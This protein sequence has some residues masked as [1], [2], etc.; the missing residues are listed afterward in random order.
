LEG[1]FVS[2]SRL[3]ATAARILHRNNA[4]DIL[5][6]L[7]NLEE[8]RAQFT[9]RWVW[10]LIQNARD[11]PDRSRPMTIRIVVSPQEIIFAHNGRDFADE[12]ILSLIYHGSTKQSNP[13][14]L[15]QFGTGFLSTHLLSKRVQVRGTL[16]DREG[17]RTGFEFNL[18]RSGDDADKVGAATRRSLDELERSLET[19]ERRPSVWTEYTY[20]IDGTLNAADLIAD[21]PFEAI[22]YILVFDQNVDKVELR[23]PERRAAYE[24]ADSEDLDTGSRL[25]VVAGVGLS[26]CYPR[27]EWHSRRCSGR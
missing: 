7:A 21:F 19:G 10:E 11:F 18:D 25:T 12:E 17:V 15:G 13:E 27:R 26:F 6:A 2:E 23:L 9:T 14:Q 20:D 5:Q 16:R 8:H 1:R 24:R 22:P 3:R 4:Q